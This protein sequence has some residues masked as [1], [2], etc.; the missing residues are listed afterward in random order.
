[1]ADFENVI[2]RT[3]FKSHVLHSL[4]ERL[5]FLYISLYRYFS[6]KQPI[7]AATRIGKWTAVCP[8]SYDRVT[9]A[10]KEKHEKEDKD[11]HK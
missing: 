1:M 6:D 8:P 11:V 3:G 4:K 9:R 7:L 2:S 10:V 5:I